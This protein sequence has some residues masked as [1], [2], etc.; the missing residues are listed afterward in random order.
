MIRFLVNVKSPCTCEW[1]GTFVHTYQYVDN[2]IDN[3]DF[4]ALCTKFVKLKGE[5]R[6]QWISPKAKANMSLSLI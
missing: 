1:A 6:N 5:R 2:F 4:M 3:G